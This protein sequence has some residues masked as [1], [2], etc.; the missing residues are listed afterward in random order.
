MPSMNEWIGAVG[1]MERAADRRKQRKDDAVENKYFTALQNNQQVDTNAQDFDSLAH[2]RA[3]LKIMEQLKSQEDYKQKQ[4][5]TIRDKIDTDHARLMEAAQHAQGFA[6]AGDQERAKR[7]LMAIYNDLIPDGYKLGYK[8]G[9]V[10]LSDPSGNVKDNDFTLEE[11]FQMLRG[12]MNKD[13]YAKT[14]LSEIAQI[15]ANNELILA[16]P[17]IL[18]NKKGEEVLVFK[19]LR[20]PNTGDPVAPQFKYRGKEITMEQ[21][22][23][24]GFISDKERTESYGVVKAGADAS[25]AGSEALKSA[26][27]AKQEAFTTKTQ[28]EDRNLDVDQKK[29]YTDYLKAGVGLRE[30]TSGEY[31]LAG[32]PVSK[33]E[34]ERAKADAVTFAKILDEE[35]VTPD[36][37]Y[38]WRT[39]I[40]DP[41]FR[42][43]LN[44]AASNA[45]DAAAFADLLRQ[46]GLP[47][48]ADN[49]EVLPR[50]Q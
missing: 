11:G 43:M 40:K 37:V 24:M 33:Q 48:F 44:A 22:R 31:I 35:A 13:D 20:D 27:E 38:R 6:A 14:L 45:D 7:T 26:E 28:E 16:E 46:L 2:H 12:V 19:G 3:Q 34:Y 29:A 36:N 10:I 50:L 30:Q 39:L 18:K 25:K 5:Q 4:H 41:T 15:K 32:A 9:K 47:E 1:I 42:G 17:E 49:I 21:A 23:E 8:D